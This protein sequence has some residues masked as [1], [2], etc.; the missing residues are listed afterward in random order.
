M[1]QKLLESDGATVI[2]ALDSHVIATPDKTVIVYGETGESLSYADFA[3]ITDAIAGNLNRVGAMPGSRVSVLTTNPFIASL[4][5]FGIW[6]AGAVFAPINPLYEG[7]LLSYQINDTAP[8]FLILDDRLNIGV[9]EILDQIEEAPVRISTSRSDAG[10]AD[11]VLSY[12]ELL[13]PAE[14]PD[15]ELGFDSPANIIYT[16]GTTGPSKGVLQTH[17]WINHYTWV[18]R[19]LLTCEDVIYNDLPMYHVGGSMHN[20]AKAVWLGASVWLWD[21]FSPSSFWDRISQSGATHATLLDVMV[22]WLMQADLA[23]DDRFNTLNKVHMQPLSVN[24]HEFGTRFGVDIITA[25]FGQTESG[26]LFAAILEETSS[27]LGTPQEMYTGLSRS[28]IE[29][30]AHRLGIPYLKASEQKT[31]GLMGRPTT[32]VDIAIVDERDVSLPDGEIGQILARP[33]LPSTMIQ[34]YIGKHQATAKAFQNL[35]FHTGD[36]GWRDA[37]GMYYF[38]DRIGDRIRVRG[39]NVSG[40]DVEAVLSTHPAI[41]LAAV[42]AVPSQ[43]SDED[44]IVAFLELADGC[45]VTVPELQEFAQ[46]SM[47]KFMRPLHYRI[48]DEIPRT[49][50]NKIEKYKLRKEFLTKG[51]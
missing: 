16:S 9:E 18:S 22:P 34:E 38:V 30:A 24:H 26:V 17:R 14:R 32:F 21:R 20:V 10:A 4:M 19:N 36:L 13:I 1:L 47:P 35:W 2:E 11:G 23:D 7:G 33:K 40:F 41:L 42:V 27:N 8:G 25:G 28:E 12:D 50:T 51:K 15:V 31:K 44:E 39:E 48:L 43:S 29:S 45:S 6:K 3:T 37:E 46:S 5:M 49:P